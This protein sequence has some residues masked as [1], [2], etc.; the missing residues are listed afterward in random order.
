MKRTSLLLLVLLMPTAVTA[1]TK[2]WTGAAGGNW[3][4]GANWADGTP[5]VA[6]D[7]LAFGNTAANRVM[8]NDLPAGTV[9]R[10]M[11]FAQQYDL[12]GNALGLS[13]GMSA[14]GAG[15]AVVRV[16]I[17]IT[18]AQTWFGAIATTDTAPI[19]LGPY[20][21][22]FSQ[23]RGPVDGVIGGTGSIIVESEV[24]FT[25][26]ET[27]TG[28]TLVR[29]RSGVMHC[30]CTL[31]GIVAAADF[32]TFIFETGAQ[33]GNIGTAG[34]TI[35]VG[36][37]PA[38]SG[39]LTLDTASTFSVHSDSTTR[40]PLAVAGTVTLDDARLELVAGYHPP[41]GTQLTLIDNDSNDPVMGTFSGLPEG[42]RFKWSASSPSAIISY[43]GGDGND[44]VLTIVPEQVTTTANLQVFPN[45]TH[46]GDQTTL[47]ATI[48]GA[49][50]PPTGIVTFFDGTTPLSTQPLRSGAAVAIVGPLAPGI[51]LLTVSY[52]PDIESFTPSRSSEVPLVVE[53]SAA[54][55]TTALTVTPPD[56]VRR[57]EPV[58]L[59]AVVTSAG[60]TPAGTVIF[61]D[62]ATVL[63]TVP[64]T[65]G[66]ASFTTSQLAVGTHVLHATFAPSNSA[67]FAF[68]VSGLTELTVTEGTVKRRAVR[69]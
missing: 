39:S 13:R 35:V 65:N 57:G 43:V 24:L 51:H 55:T 7:D 47:I 52:Q 48:T 49:D 5:P 22:T 11:S 20:T 21:L 37:S 64:L 34:G 18:G 54:A 36:D 61:A 14:S 26:A 33:T 46:T 4:N 41:A 10:S 50:E 59:T 16:P 63:A 27:F 56:S 23:F 69:P 67:A 8:V 53:G 44:V 29:G 17:A 42:A 31:P 40:S 19:D 1:A 6:G 9:Y 68:S 60:G 12:S 58:T 25:A 38:H 30:A 15:D 3:S 2:S 32:A 45:P 66:S 62:A 28:S